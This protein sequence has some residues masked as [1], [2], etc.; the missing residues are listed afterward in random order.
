MKNKSPI[1]RDRALCFLVY[2]V[3]LVYLVEQN[4]LN[5]P[6]E[7]INRSLP[8][9]LVLHHLFSLWHAVGDILGIGEIDHCA[10]PH[11]FGAL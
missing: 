7:P 3:C 8:L 4:R 5:R 10:I 1:P 9:Q 11:G 6:D 2:F